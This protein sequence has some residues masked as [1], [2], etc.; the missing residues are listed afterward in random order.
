MQYRALKVAYKVSFQDGILEVLLAVLAELAT[1]PPA[2]VPAVCG[3]G[4]VA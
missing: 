3:K 4:W 2:V 1:L